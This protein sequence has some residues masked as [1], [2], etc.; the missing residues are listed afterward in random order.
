MVQYLTCKGCI[1]IF[2][3]IFKLMLDF[4]FKLH[5]L[6]QF[7]RLCIVAMIVPAFVLYFTGV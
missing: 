2:A 3:I 5:Y 7:V 4:C 1:K 6:K